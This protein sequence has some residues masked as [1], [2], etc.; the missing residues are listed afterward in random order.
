MMD[1]R[2]WFPDTEHDLT[3]LT[4]AMAGEAGEVA[5]QLKKAIRGDVDLDTSE[6]MVP[7]AFELTD[8]LIYLCMIANVCDI[9]LAETYKIKREI[10]S[11]RFGKT[12]Q[13]GENGSSSNGMGE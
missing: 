8:V 2:D 7:F 3:F 13:S 11:G 10:N 9:D 6:G 12:D 1:T 4:L 5:N